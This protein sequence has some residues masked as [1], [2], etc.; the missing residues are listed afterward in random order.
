MT[1]KD[2]FL[3]QLE[4]TEELV[5]EEVDKPWLVVPLSNTNRKTYT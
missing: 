1:E 5:F 2:R 4:V 3:P